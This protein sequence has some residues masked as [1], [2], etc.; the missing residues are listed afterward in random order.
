MAFSSVTETQSRHFLTLS[1]IKGD[2]AWDQGAE[3]VATNNDFATTWVADDPPGW[4]VVEVGDATSNL[5]EDANG[6]QM[7]TDGSA[8]VSVNQAISTLDAT[9]KY[10]VTCSI[11]TD[12]SGLIRV[13]LN[14]PVGTVADV[15]NNSFNVDSVGITS[16][17]LVPQ[18]DSE[19]GIV[20]C[21]D[22]VASNMV[23]DGISVREQGS[24]WPDGMQLRS[25]DFHA[26]ADNDI[27]V[28][29]DGGPAGPIIFF[30]KRTI[31][32]TG[33]Q[34]VNFGGRLVRPYINHGECTLN[35]SSLVMFQFA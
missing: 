34:P 7:L 27:L 4:T 13:G 33:Q 15:A 23:I 22:D 10:I 31:L 5:T 18:D 26:A 14:I 17:Q 6:A 21:A 19:E 16:D 35:A 8:R 12:T 9:K 1:A 30:K 25:I 29:R 32:D 11:E 24:R 20:I 3:L 28:I 2:W